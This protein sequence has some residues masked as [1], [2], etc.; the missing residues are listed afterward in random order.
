MKGVSEREKDRGGTDQCNIARHI[1]EGIEKDIR[2]KVYI[3]TKK[4]VVKSTSS[5]VGYRIFYE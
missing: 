1:T 5:W 4:R 2:Y 3:E